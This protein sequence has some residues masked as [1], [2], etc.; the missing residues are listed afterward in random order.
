VI[1]TDG[2]I[3]LHVHVLPGLD[4]GPPTVAAAIDLLRALH[5]Q[6]VTAVVAVAHAFDGRYRASREA[7]LAATEQLERARPP[8]L[9][10]MTIIPSMEVGLGADTLRAAERRELLAI[11]ASPYIAVDLPRGQ[12]PPFA[13]EMLF[14]LMLAGYRPIVMHPELNSD[15]RRYPERLSELSRRGILAM[16]SAPALLGRWGRAPQRTA[17]RFLE[18]GEASLI[19]SDAH[20]TLNR[21]PLLAAALAARAARNRGQPLER[22][23]FLAACG[24]DPTSTQSEGATLWKQ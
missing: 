24:R 20:D 21:P 16:V 7:I 9:A 10:G 15:L 8:E 11:G 14:G 1:A 12:F 6:G 19:A 2:L 4:D 22:S 3:D 23:L 13:E 17:A 5:G 18:R